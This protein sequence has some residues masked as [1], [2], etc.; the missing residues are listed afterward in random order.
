MKEANFITKEENV[1]EIE[2]ETGN[3]FVCIKD[4]EPQTM[5]AVSLLDLL[6][7]LQKAPV[8]KKLIT[9]DE[10]DG[11]SELEYIDFAQNDSYYY[12]M[13]EYR[14]LYERTL[15][16]IYGGVGRHYYM[17]DME[18]CIRTNDFPT[19]Y[20]NIYKP[21]GYILESLFEKLNQVMDS[22][23]NGSSKAYKLSVTDWGIQEIDGGDKV[24]INLD[25]FKWECI[26]DSAAS[27]DGESSRVLTD[28]QKI[29][30]VNWI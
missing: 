29:H 24:K 17:P 23:V 30:I 26:T 10:Y 19:E 5:V 21:D 20:T 11:Y 6:K 25:G 15:D 1:I 2:K 22:D 27:E 4:K 14:I 3:I 16:L 7:V 8:I 12:M 13:G 28:K 9:Y 18:E